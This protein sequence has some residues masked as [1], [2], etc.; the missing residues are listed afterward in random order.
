MLKYNLSNFNVIKN[1]RKTKG[2]QDYVLDIYK[3]QELYM[4]SILTCSFLMIFIGIADRY[5]VQKIYRP[6]PYKKTGKLK[7]IA[8]D[9]VL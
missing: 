2:L 4:C 1:I 9:K 5:E 7:K 3:F 8:C 6:I